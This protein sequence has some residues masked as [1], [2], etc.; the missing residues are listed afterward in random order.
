M[1]LERNDG[2]TCRQ[3]HGCVPVR[4]A[5]ILLYS[6]PVKAMKGNEERL[7]IMRLT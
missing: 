4:S 1:R 6:F 2:S 3:P 5:K 7:A